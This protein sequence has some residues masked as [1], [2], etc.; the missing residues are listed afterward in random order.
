MKLEEW[1]AGVWRW[2][3]FSCGFQRTFS[4]KT[5]IKALDRD[6]GFVWCFY[7]GQHA[8]FYAHVI[9]SNLLEPPRYRSSAHPQYS[10]GQRTG[11]KSGWGGG[12]GGG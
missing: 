1:T 10:Q 9:V 4:P 6:L 12:G 3:I 2:M 5:A 11:S 8:H 7:M